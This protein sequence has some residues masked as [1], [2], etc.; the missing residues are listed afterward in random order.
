MKE[1]LILEEYHYGGMAL[2]G[3]AQWFIGEGEDG[4]SGSAAVFLTSEGMN[5]ISGNHTRARWVAMSGRL[6]GEKASVVAMG[7]PT[8][9]RAPQHVR[10]HSDKPYFCYAPMVA[11]EFR[12]EPGKEYVSRFRFLTMDGTPEVKAIDAHWRE[13]AKASDHRE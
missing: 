4:K 10:I 12:I 9:F 3:S 13:Y 8:N 1:P 5:R 2:R 6:D 7:S 11:G